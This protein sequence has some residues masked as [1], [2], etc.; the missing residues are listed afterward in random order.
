MNDK[1]TEGVAAA[2]AG[3]QP[4]VSEI[5]EVYAR[6]ACGQVPAELAINLPTNSKYGHVA[7]N[8]CGDWIL[9]FKAGYPKSNEHLVKIATDAWNAAPRWA[10]E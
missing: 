10:P 1:V 7:G 6:C 4:P 8:C 2:I 3:E 9:E 5:K